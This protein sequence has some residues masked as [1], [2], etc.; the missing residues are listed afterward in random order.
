M[1][2]KICTSLVKTKNK[3]QFSHWCKQCYSHEQQPNLTRPGSVQNSTQLK[4][5]NILNM[6]TP[7]TEVNKRREY[8]HNYT[9]HDT[10]HQNYHA[11]YR[12]QTRKIDRA[13]LYN[14]DFLDYKPVSIKI[15]I[16]YQS[17]AAHHPKVIIE[18]AVQNVTP[19]L[20]LNSPRN[21]TI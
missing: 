14:F 15:Q 21:R 2:L 11:S 3:R 4:M 12:R 20:P 17:T 5:L 1:Y 6:C 16:F 10:W 7:L 9:G 18:A 13:N 8:L 19:S